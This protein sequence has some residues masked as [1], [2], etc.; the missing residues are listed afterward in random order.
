MTDLATDGDEL[1]KRRVV[2]TGCGVVCPLGCTPQALGESLRAGRSGVAPI[3]SIPTA[4]VPVK[5]GG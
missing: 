1:M 3:T 4:T 2:I 5:P